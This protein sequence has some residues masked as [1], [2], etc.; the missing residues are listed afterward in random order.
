MRAVAVVLAGVAALAALAAAG[1]GGGGD[2]PSLPQG[3][4]LAANQTVTPRVHLFAEPVVA[5]VDVIVDGD[6]Y[7]PD[8]IRLVSEFKPYEETRGATRT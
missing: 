6:R 3:R 1:C 8:R 7:D 4:F 5:R 2:T